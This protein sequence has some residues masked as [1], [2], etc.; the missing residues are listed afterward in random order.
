MP[1][2]KA[3]RVCQFGDRKSEAFQASDPRGLLLADFPWNAWV[4]SRR[5]TL[6][7]V[8]NCARHLTDKMA[9]PRA[10]LLLLRRLCLRRVTQTGRFFT[11]SRSVQALSSAKS[12]RKDR[13]TCKTH[14]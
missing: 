10:A 9:S 2:A 13:T 4:S 3:Y 6:T 7:R 1:R 5:R 11:N 12:Q 14:F 8:L